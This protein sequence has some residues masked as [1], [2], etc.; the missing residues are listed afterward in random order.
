MTAQEAM[1]LAKS[2]KGQLPSHENG[3]KVEDNK[4]WNQGSQRQKIYE[5][6]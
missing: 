2:I 3:F 4:F 1:E 5:N 6:I